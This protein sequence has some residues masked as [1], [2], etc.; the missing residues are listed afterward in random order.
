M[1]ESIQ[2]LGARVFSV[3]KPAIDLAV[4]QITKLVQGIDTKTI[5]SILTSVIDAIAKFF[6]DIVNIAE[7][8]GILI[9]A[10]GLKIRSLLAPL[11]VLDYVTDAIASG[12]KKMADTV[13]GMVSTSKKVE[14]TTTVWDNLRK[15]IEAARVA[16]QGFVNAQ[17]AVTPPHA[18]GANMGAINFDAAKASADRLKVIQ[19]EYK[20]RNDLIQKDYGDFIFSEGAKTQALL[21]SLNTRYQEEIKAGEKTSVAYAKFALDRQKII[22]AANK[23]YEAGLNNAF[24]GLQ[25]AI[26]GQLRGMLAGTTTF[27][28]AF[29]S[30]IGDMIIWAIQEFEKMAFQWVAHELI[31]TTATEA[32]TAARVSA[33]A[34]GTAATETLG[35]ASTLK[36]IFQSAAKTF[37]G[38]FGFLAPE[39]GPAAAAPAFGAEGMV[40]AQSLGIAGLDVGTDYV[41]KTGLAVIHQG[42]AVVPAEANT[43]FTGGT[44]GQQVSLTINAIDAKSFS[45]LIRDNPSVFATMIKRAMRDNQMSFKGAH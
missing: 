9:D 13:D 37:A 2:S 7:Q 32:G 43:P 45:S 26:N 42:E 19:D 10:V 20:L 18:G 30:I 25:S 4:T 5:Q 36:S 29:K 31:K 22:D 17:G 14:Q 35:I 8:I 27:A 15:T 3:L 16:A 23:V 40:V 12:M 6:L 33:E 44:G 39:M 34:T 21:A 11:I 41:A 24:S 38:V 1:S 28:Q